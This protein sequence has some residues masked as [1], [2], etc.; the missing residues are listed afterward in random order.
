MRDGQDGGL[1]GFPR[2]EHG[3]VKIGYRGVKFSNPTVQQDGK[4]RSIP[5]TR[6][7]ENATRQL[8]SFAASR[9]KR[10]VQHLMP[11]LLPYYVQ[12]RLCP[13]T[14][15]FDNHFVID[16]VPGQVRLMVVTAGSGHAFKF[17]PTI[18]GAVVD[19]IEGIANRDLDMWRWRA[20]EAGQKPYNELMQ[21]LESP[22]ALKQQSMTVDDS[23]DS[24]YARL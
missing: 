21:G 17:L 5:R 3:F 1:Y 10:I 18:G 23:L 9:I 4:V 11:E 8:P 19:R 15:S 12:S 22:L 2:D 7:T 24:H 6:W 16:F 14:D 13:Y 20:L